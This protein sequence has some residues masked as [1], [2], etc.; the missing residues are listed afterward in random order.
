MF[1]S[2]ERGSTLRDRSNI[3]TVETVVVD[4]EIDHVGEDD[5]LTVRWQLEGEPVAVNVSIGT[6]PDH[7]SHTQ[8][9]TVP[10]GETSI[11]VMRPSGG[12]LYVSVASREGGPAVVAAERRISFD[13]VS[14]FRDLG[15]Y[16]IR[17]GRRVQWGRVFRSDALHGMTEGDLRVYHELGLRAVYDLRGDVEVAE[18]R[19]PVPSRSLPILTRPTT[20]VAPLGFDG[21]TSADGEQV[22]ADIY[23]RSLDHSAPRIGEL[24]S[25]L[26]E[27]D[28][29]PAV[30]HCHARKDRTGLVAALLLEALAVDRES[31]LDDY[32]LTA[33]YRLRTQQDQT[34]ERLLKAGLA[35]EVAAGVL[36]TPRWAMTAALAHLD[37]ECG[38]IEGYLTGPAAMTRPDL[39]RLADALL[40]P[41]VT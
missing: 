37:R 32:E 23:I 20:D 35:P 14:N 22:L 1:R 7:T 5:S 38:N 9:A 10:A 16:R 4:V 30:F 36:T 12:R 33:R 27:P 28:G 2:R 39:R 13:A 29:L 40:T 6:S 19:N 8:Q 21:T 3:V 17:S 15:G 25:A 26:T 41:Q 31:I 18:Q 11:P 24:F 34:F